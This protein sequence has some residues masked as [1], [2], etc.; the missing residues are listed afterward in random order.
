MTRECPDNNRVIETLTF[1]LCPNDKHQFIT[2][3]VRLRMVTDYIRMLLKDN[4]NDN[5]Y[6][7]CIYPEV[8]YPEKSQDG[9]MARIHFHGILEFM[10]DHAKPQFYIEH[11]HHINKNCRMEVDTIEDY[12]GWRE[13]CTKNWSTMIPYCER[14]K[15]PYRITHTLGYP[16]APKTNKNIKNYLSQPISDDELEL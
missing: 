11:F 9:S 6:N 15:V 14:Q 3:P 1:T 12:E 2:S 5:E 10:S 16:T 13:Y 4:L 8:S 7:Y